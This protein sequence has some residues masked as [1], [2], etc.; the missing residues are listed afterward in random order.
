[1]LKSNYNGL[2]WCSQMLSNLIDVLCMCWDALRCFQR[3][4]DFLRKVFTDVLETFSDALDV[5]KIYPWYHKDTPVGLVGLVVLV[6]LVG[7]CRSGGVGWSCGF[8][9][10]SVPTYL[11]TVHFLYLISTFKQKYGLW[12]SPILLWA[13]SQ[14]SSYELWWSRGIRWSPIP[15][16][17]MIHKELNWK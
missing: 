9:W 2:S 15:M 4:R 12:W 16:S 7:L 17:S 11:I 5:P 6:G 1:M 13:A 8:G 14:F 3:V 10:S